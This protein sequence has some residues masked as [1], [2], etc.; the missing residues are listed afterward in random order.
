MPPGSSDNLS[1]RIE[2]TIKCSS[3][4]NKDI[5]SKSDPMCILTLKNEDIG[6]FEEIGRTERVENNLNPEFTTKLLVT[7]K[8][9]TKQML[10]FK[11]YDCDDSKNDPD[12]ADKLGTLTVSVA[13]VVQGRLRGGRPLAKSGDSNSKI[14]VT[15]RET[16]DCRQNYV[17][18]F[19]ALGLDN[20]D[21]L[22]KSD[23]FLV[24]HRKEGDDFTPVGQT[25]VIDNN[26][27]P[28]WGAFTINF[29][30]FCNNDKKL[31]IKV[32]CYDFDSDGSHDLIGA[33]E[34]T[35]EELL[36]GVGN[37]IEFPLI[38][39]K[40]KA[41]K[42][43]YKHSGVLMLESF[44]I[45]EEWE[46][47]HYVQSGLQMGFTV[48]IDFTGSNGNPA[49][50]QSLHFFNP[51]QPVNQYTTAIESV[52]NVVQEYDSDKMFPVYGFGGRF[53]TQDRT[54]HCFPLNNDLSNPNVMGVQGI[55]D[56][57]RYAL[58]TSTL[59][60]P[61][62]FSEVI[63]SATYLASQYQS[64]L[65]YFILL[66]IT[67]GAITDMEQTKAE[68]VAASKYPMSIIIVG[69]GMAD[70]ES[71]EEL[72][73]DKK[74][75]EDFNGTKAVRD[76]VQFVPLREVIPPYSDAAAMARSQQKLA[77][78]VLAEIPKQV[79]LYMKSR[80]LNPVDIYNQYM[81][82]FPQAQNAV[83]VEAPKS[84][85]AGC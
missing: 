1:S 4:K 43:S 13:E 9:E 49:Y 22:G 30:T 77:Q 72:D 20:K 64:G 80:G 65:H 6:K 82:M 76:I 5:G 7:Y 48:A 61:T 79:K 57:Y 46:F 69:V 29:A 60:G 23:P 14:Y 58:S 39:E 21:F 16:T 74:A 19:I 35:T 53:F 81:Q 36:Q 59:S 78:K 18:S 37:K 55:L 15:A 26:L 33:C 11:I 38:N 62:N 40:K 50:P 67:D 10:K 41:K 71:M 24:F 70:F 47:S 54:S 42:K 12:K 44:R 52:G 28:R 68:I 75:L 45:E 3:L 66:I 31:P 17:F 83:P 34:M 73:S 51:Q 84:E 2:L 32:V 25:E 8:F 63:R 56:A 27:N 85:N